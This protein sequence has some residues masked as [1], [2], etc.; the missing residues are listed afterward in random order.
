MENAK[1][2]NQIFE[3]IS[4]GAFFVLWGFTLLFPSLPN[5]I[6]TIGI[7]LILISM[8]IAR[9]R[10]GLPVSV[11]TMTLG[12]LAV[13]LGSLELV[14]PYFNISFEIPY[15]AVLLI[16]FGGSLITRQLKESRN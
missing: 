6:G 15:F 5:A 13:L 2:L 8:N 14:L 16:V 7:G 12:I 10:N 9:S 11:F 3:T 1:K 4:W